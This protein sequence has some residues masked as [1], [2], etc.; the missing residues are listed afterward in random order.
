M[1]I[2]GFIIAIDSYLV[3]KGMV[4][5]LNRLH[6][7]R[8]VKEFDRADPL[9]NHMKT[10]RADYL[11]LSQSIFNQATD[12]YVS[13]P[14]L[15]ERTILVKQS[16]SPQGKE[17]V[18]A[19][20]SLSEGKEEIV[21]KIVGFLKLR[22]PESHEDWIRVLTQREVTIVRMVSKGLTNKQIAGELF[23]STHTVTTHRK[24]ITRKLGIKSVSGLTVYAIVNNII[25]M[26]EVV[27]KPSQ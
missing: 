22:P 2:S 12:L 6:G 26:E 9:L 20:I 23:L 14:D 19:S 7:V 15:L 11:I 4:S 5:L 25:S 24:N 8:V 17:D 18:H 16:L 10:N 1:R 21:E 27:S 13:N 3:R